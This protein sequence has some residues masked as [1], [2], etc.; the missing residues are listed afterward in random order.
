MVPAPG[1][2]N[3]EDVRADGTQGV[4]R[5]KNGLL[6]LVSAFASPLWYQ[7]EF[8]GQFGPLTGQDGGNPSIKTLP[9]KLKFYFPVRKNLPRMMFFSGPHSNV[10]DA[11]RSNADQNSQDGWNNTEKA[12]SSGRKQRKPQSLM[13]SVLE[14]INRSAGFMAH[15]AY[16]IARCIRVPE[17]LPRMV[18]TWLEAV[19]GH[20]KHS[21]SFLKCCKCSGP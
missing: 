20:M 18:F 16:E 5:H 11:I 19:R 21:P 12:K 15:E 7:V 10:C 8:D 4:C 3:F 6:C 17:E 2:K 14:A 13:S 1:G 9:M